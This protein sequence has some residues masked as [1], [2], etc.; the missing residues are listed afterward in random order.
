MYS[1][2]L[3][4]SMLCDW[5]KVE[6]ESYW[7]RPLGKHVMDLYRALYYTKSDP[8]SARVICTSAVTLVVF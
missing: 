1:L 7:D 8:G 3:R 6:L 2:V 5:T 4:N